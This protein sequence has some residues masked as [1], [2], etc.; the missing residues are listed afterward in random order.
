MREPATGEI[1]NLTLFFARISGAE[2]V[3]NS[4]V[5]PDRRAVS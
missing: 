4:Q 2:C 1:A 5:N 3:I